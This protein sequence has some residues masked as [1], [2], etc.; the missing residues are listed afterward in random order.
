MRRASA[1]NSSILFFGLMFAAGC[2]G[3]AQD[4]QAQGPD[5]IAKLRFLAGTWTCTFS[6]EG[7]TFGAI[8]HP[9]YRFFGGGHWISERSDLRENGQ[10]ESEIQLWGYD[11]QQHKLVA[12]QFVSGGLYSKTVLGWQNGEFVSRRD[13]NG[14]WV[15][16]R[17]HGARAFDWVIQ[18]SDKSNTVV[19]A[20]KK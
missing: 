5:A 7:K 15:S 10:D 9:S 12:R 4:A 18:S 14:A 2:T 3:Y 6:R 19:E 17:P 13:D 11:D 16:I 1:L 20:C 8:D